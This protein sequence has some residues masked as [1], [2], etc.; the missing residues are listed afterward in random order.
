MMPLRLVVA[1]LAVASFPLFARAEDSNSNNIV[2]EV[3]SDY[4]EPNFLDTEFNPFDPNAEQILDLYDQYYELET[5]NSAFPFR[6]GTFED[7]LW[8]VNTEGC[9]RANCRVYAQVVRS[10]QRLYLYVNGQHVDTWAVSTGDRGHG[11]PNF[12]TWPNGRVYDRY[13]SKSFPGGDYNG[14]GNM[15]FA[16]FIDGGFAI[17]GTPRGNWGKLGQRAS[18]GCIRVHPDNGKRFNRLVRESGIRNTFITVE[19][20][21]TDPFANVAIKRL[22]R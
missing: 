16:V 13:S 4:E 3:R 12:E 6:T 8:Q 18:H 11:T 15:P 2:E 20:V 7:Y 1:L 19:E 17:H 9:K 21:R 14:L 22:R 10:E 5:G